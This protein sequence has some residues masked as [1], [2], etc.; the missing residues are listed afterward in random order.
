MVGCSGETAWL[1]S[2]LPLAWAGHVCLGLAMGVLGPTQ[3]FL[4]TQVNNLDNEKNQQC[5]GLLLIFVPK[6]GVPNKQINFIWTG[7]AL[8]TCIA[9]V[10]TSFVFRL[11]IR[12]S[13]QKLTFLA[14]GL[15]GTGFFILLIP[16]ITSFC[17]LLSA[18][19]LVGFSL[20]CFDSADNSLF[21][22]MLGPDRSAPFIQ[23][24]HA[25]V[26][27]GFT[28]GG[29]CMKES[30][31][32]FSSGSLLV[33][34]FL[35]PATTSNTI[36]QDLGLLSPH[37]LNLSMINLTSS[38]LSL[39]TSEEENTISVILEDVDVHPRHPWLHTIPDLAWPFIIIALGNLV[40]ATAFLVLG[41]FT[42]FKLPT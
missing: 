4:A 6:V 10:I 36:C 34:P 5:L 20:G 37:A 25:A 21:V 31:K 40:T 1:S 23:S 12:K 33:H 39:T 26:A 24:L 35:P 28:L 38:N 17:F 3:P 19:L 2:Y 13:W 22:Y 29:F 32:C 41:T 42:V 7:R 9:A 14:F 11:Y 15:L 18:L 27:L 30:H 8:G 16:W